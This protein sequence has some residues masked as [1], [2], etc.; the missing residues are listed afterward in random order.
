[1]DNAEDIWKNHAQKRNKHLMYLLGLAVIGIIIS[2]ITG[3]HLIS[4]I[5]LAAIV[6]YVLAWPVRVA[7]TAG[8]Y[9]KGLRAEQ[10]KEKK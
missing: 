6:I 1:M 4:L 10:N 5:A 3:I 8:K 7:V 2:V 9:A